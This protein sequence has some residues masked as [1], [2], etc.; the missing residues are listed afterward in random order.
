M[1]FKNIHTLTLTIIALSI[2]FL[3]CSV[4]PKQPSEKQLEF[5]HELNKMPGILKAEWYNT[6]SLQVTVNLDNLGNN[7]KLK[8]QQLADQI[9]SAGYQIT[10]QGLCVSIY[11]PNLNKLAGT[12]VTD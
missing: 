9:A 4:E 8:A 3:S 10:G 5:A 11:Y 1:S 6:I 7:P 12:C 2:L